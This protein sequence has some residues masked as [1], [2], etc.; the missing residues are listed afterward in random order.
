MS[1][2]NSYSALPSIDRKM[3]E[4]YLM[5]MRR[6]DREITDKSKIDEIIRGC[7]C[8]RLGFCDKGQVYIV[9]LN[10]GFIPKAGGGTLYFHGA[11]AGR[12]YQ[13]LQASPTVTFEMDR[14]YWLTGG[15]VA[16]DYACHFQSVMGQGRASIISDPEEKLVALKA[17]MNQAVTH[18]H[19]NALPQETRPHQL[20][21]PEMH[22]RVETC[23]ANKIHPEGT[24]WTFQQKMLE[25]T[26]VFKVEITELS[27]KE[28]E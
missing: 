19:K 18:H 2:F 4:Q 22:P 13:L 27:C 9:P 16:C 25:V 5:I 15:E 26:C 14:E 7:H 17:L 28:H 12:K 11:K 24:N 6:K 21:S 1:R 20:P 3:S 8:C 10:F 23:P